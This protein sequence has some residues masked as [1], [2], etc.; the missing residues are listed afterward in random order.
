MPAITD[1]PGRDSGSGA[2]VA[3]WLNARAPNWLAP[4]VTVLALT[5]GAVIIV[6]AGLIAVS[7]H[8]VFVARW[9]VDALLPLLLT[10]LGVLLL[11]ALIVGIRGSLTAEASF[12]V[13]AGVQRDL[14]RSLAQ[15]QVDRDE[16]SGA[17]ISLFDEQVENL[18]P[19]YTRFLP[20]RIQAVVVPIVV[21]I[22]VV[23]SDWLAAALLALSAPLI[24]LFMVLVGQGAQSRAH[25]QLEAMA[26]LGGWFL[27]RIRGAAT[28]RLF[29]AEADSLAQV[30]THT[31][32]LRRATMHVLRL[33]FL[34]SAVLEF[35]SAVAIA[36]VAIYVGMGLIGFIQFGPA[37]DLTLTSGL[38][39]LLLAPEFFAPLRAL[40]Q[41]WHDR[42]GAR[43]AGAA[44]QAV[45]RRPRARPSIG[46]RIA[47]EPPSASSIEL[48][49]VHFSHPGRG[50]LFDGLDLQVAAGQRVVLVGP[51]G[52]GKSTLIALMAG[53]VQPEGGQ[54]RIDGQ[55]L[56]RMTDA[57][58]AAHVG[59]LSQRPTLFAGSVADNIALGLADCP[60]DDVEAA[61]RIAGVT[62]FTDRLDEGLAARIGEGGYGLSG[63]QAQRVAL[64][65]M[66]LEPRP[67]I[68]LDEPTAGLDDRGE[69]AF[70]AALDRMLAARAATVVYATHRRAMVAWADRV[71][72]VRE[73]CVTGLLASP[74]KGRPR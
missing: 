16:S 39:V 26:R 38:F 62:E 55:P 6:Q 23:F 56:A 50:R 42:A 29:G 45:L 13:R 67:L 52:G 73:G 46:P 25:S 64:A 22:A 71:L 74:M 37:D 17:R 33:A 66:L 36:T 51:S 30:R 47:P 69:A 9:P 40:S 4:A 5:D 34:S 20:Q 59:W 32:G 2:E 44:I 61:A 14:L 21:L 15:A 10:L 70:L 24:P 35:F 72:E 41:G 27:D 18:D 12:R 49:G 68:L 43:A 11:R 3:D 1:E 54:V 60:A 19:F 7:A 63:G 57:A 53:F 28:L 31:D 8:A 48:V 58:R 65:R